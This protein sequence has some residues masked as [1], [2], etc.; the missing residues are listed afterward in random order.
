MPEGPKAPPSPQNAAPD[1]LPKPTLAGEIAK[2]R[3]GAAK[4]VIGGAA[5]DT[6]GHH[7]SDTI[8]YLLRDRQPM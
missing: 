4:D 7:C 2:V 5:K 6:T 1:T 8:L 3:G